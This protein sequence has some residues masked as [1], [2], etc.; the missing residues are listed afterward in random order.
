[1]YSRCHS[2]K[3]S[4]TDWPFPSHFIPIP[5]P[6]PHESQSSKRVAPLSF[7]TPLPESAAT[8]PSAKE[9]HRNNSA[10]GLQ[11]RNNPFARTPLH[12]LGFG[13][14]PDLGVE[15]ASRSSF[16]S[17]LF[18]LSLPGS[19]TAEQ[20][21]VVPAQ[22]LPRS[23]RALGVQ[24]DCIS[25]TQQRRETWKH[26]KTR[27]CSTSHTPLGSVAEATTKSTIPPEKSFLKA[28]NYPLALPGSRNKSK[29]QFSKARVFQA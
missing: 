28:T 7:P 8:A 10:R 20:M 5:P 14:K 16:S 25:S 23:P 26:T 3:P 24:R 22:V 19:G 18:Q 11:A 21:A 17:K 9:K 12:G 4:H 1:M 29:L 2:K 27:H 6:K 13:R 15:K